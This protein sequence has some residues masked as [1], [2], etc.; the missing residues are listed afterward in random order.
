LINKT[1][2]S[3]KRHIVRVAVA[4]ALV[5]VPLGALAVTASA[6]T[7]DSA[8]T[9]VQAVSDQIP[10]VGSA[11]DRP[12]RDDWDGPRGDDGHGR[13]DRHGP[14]DGPQFPQFPP[15]TGSAG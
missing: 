5:T 10:L 3:F 14:G 1:S 2:T 13:G 9:T 12:H 7:P 11:I 8:G 4:G 15:P 6:A